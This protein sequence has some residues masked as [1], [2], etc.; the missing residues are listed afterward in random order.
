MVIFVKKKNNQTKSK[1]NLLTL[2]LNEKLGFPSNGT[3]CK[4][5]ILLRLIKNVLQKEPK[6]ALNIINI[7]EFGCIRKLI[8]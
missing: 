4:K 5:Q 2:I 8:F 3:N 1:S 7:L 6:A